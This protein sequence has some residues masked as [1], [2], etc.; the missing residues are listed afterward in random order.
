MRF[1]D[2]LHEHIIVIIIAVVVLAGVVSTIFIFTEKDK[3]EAG[4]SESTKYEE[5]DTVYFAMDHVASLN[6]LTSVDSDTYY[7][8]Q[9]LFSSLFRLD[10]SLNVEKDLV[11]SYETDAEEGSVDIKLKEGLKFSDGSDLTAYDVNYTINQIWRIG[12]DSPYYAYASKIDSVNVSGDRSL[13]V[14]FASP[15]DAA[16]DNLVFPIV[17]S[18]DFDWDANKTLGS[19]PYRISSYNAKKYLK[20]RVNNEYYGPKAKNKVE[21]K[22]VRDKDVTPGLMTT[23]AVTAYVSRDMNADAEGEDKQLAVTPIPSSEMEFLG[24]NFTNRHLAKKE[25]RQA[26]ALAID[27]EN[28]IRDNYGDNAVSSDSIY[29]PGFLGEGLAQDAYPLNQKR[30][31]ELLSACGYKDADK[32]GIL[33]D[34]KGREVSLS[35][36]VN[37]GNSSRVDCA[38]SIR[39][40]LE[41][42]GVKVTVKTKGRADYETAIEERDF[43]MYLG[44]YLFD[45]QYDLRKLFQDAKARGF[46]NK[47]IQ[48]LVAKLETCLTAEEQKAVFAELK[49]LLKTELPYYALCSKNYSFITVS[50]FESEA[51]PTFFDVFRG[52]GFWSWQ[53]TVTVKEEAEEETEENEAA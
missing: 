21:F 53:K 6:P 45:K 18:A 16:L 30:A 48:S 44:G 37:S 43:Q 52:C 50:H 27:T 51:P 13:T 24:F 17:S 19:G 39:D 32:N 1:V 14:N 10:S 47:E 34:E 29:F 46:D 40:Q 4:L 7:I 33:E 38:E 36:L 23:D 41:K 20:L 8:S 28:L 11:E 31:A 22:I 35:I 12:K 25:F 5:A 26:I 49:P 42:I 15:A 3:D 2:Y 9:L